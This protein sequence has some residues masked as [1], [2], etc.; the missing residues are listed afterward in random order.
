[1][2]AWQHPHSFG[3]EAKQGAE[4]RTRWV[5]LLTLVT[6][7]VEL[8]AGYMTGSM[9]LTADG[10]HMSTHAAALGITAFAYAFARRHA[11]NPRFTFGTGKVGT[12]GAFA[13]AVAL[14]IVALLM[15][16]E[17]VLR[18]LEPVPVRFSEAIAVAF[19]GLVVNI[20]SAWLLA[21]GTASHHHSHG[22]DHDYGHGHHSPHHKDHN[23]RAAYLHVLADAMTSV[24]ALIALTCGMFLGWVWMDPLM[25]IVGSVV[26]GVW[27]YGLL[28]DSSKVLLD[29]EDNALQKEAVCKAL[30]ETGDVDIADLHFWRVGTA[31]HACIVSL[32][33]HDPKPLEFYKAALSCISGLE[34]ITVEINHCC[35]EV[36]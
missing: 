2:A 26:I 31:S 1:M 14:A 13:S 11:R 17:S 30:G 36:K 7:V 20:L 15:T 29:A 33:A 34:H 8:V 22:H 24:T 16:A 4:I 27:S 25:G 21:G 28:R 12:L 32:V 18:L 3:L 6:M 5:I 19:V 23:L 9:A 35:T 10:W